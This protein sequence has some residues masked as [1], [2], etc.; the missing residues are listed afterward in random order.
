MKVSPHNRITFHTKQ[1][2]QEPTKL[3]FS[4]QIKV[5]LSFSFL[6]SN[7]TRRKNPITLATTPRLQ[8]AENNLLYDRL[9]FLMLTVERRQG[10]NR[11]T[12]VTWNFSMPLPLALLLIQ[13]CHSDP[14]SSHTE[15]SFQN[16]VSL[17]L[18]LHYFYIQSFFYLSCQMCSILHGIGIIQSYSSRGSVIN[19][20]LTVYWHISHLPL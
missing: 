19:L 2:C 6:L 16:T 18:Q 1:S 8:A 13:S 12:R 5:L 14:M 17:L 7:Q 20:S 11:Q 9:P 10:M 3:N 15:C 4:V